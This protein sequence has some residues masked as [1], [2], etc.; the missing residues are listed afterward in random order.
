MKGHIT[1]CQ[2]SVSNLFWQNVLN[3]K[4]K[5][6]WKIKFYFYASLTVMYIIMYKHSLET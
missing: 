3:I 4:V 2:S 5:K 6:N 1:L